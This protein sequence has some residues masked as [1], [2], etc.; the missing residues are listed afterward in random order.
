MA[1]LRRPAGNVPAAPGVPVIFHALPLAGAFV[2]EIDAHPDERGFF[3]RTY[4]RAEFRAHGLATDYPQ[5]S[6][7]FNQ[8]KGTLR[9]MHFQIAPHQE[10]KLVRCT[11][12][13]LYDVV[14]DLRPDSKTY[15][16][17]AGV[18]LEARRRNALY[19]PEGFAHGFLTLEHAGVLRRP[20]SVRESYRR[21][22]GLYAD[23]LAPPS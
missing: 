5:C 9:G 16:R 11:R 13:A 12:G 8:R 20:A 18:E 10:A 22:I 14:V 17:W 6:V 3:A 7:S 4:D 19:V 15:C 2:V 1:T 23:A 21:M